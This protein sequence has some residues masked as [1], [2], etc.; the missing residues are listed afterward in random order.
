MSRKIE[1]LDFPEHRKVVYFQTVNNTPDVRYL[2]EK[3]LLTEKVG[4]KKILGLNVPSK[5]FKIFKIWKF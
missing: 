5:I 1:N 2:T 3:C 4:Y